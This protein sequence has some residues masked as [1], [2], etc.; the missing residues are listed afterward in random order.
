M[1][2]SPDDLIQVNLGDRSYPIVV[3]SGVSGQIAKYI[4]SGVS[5]IAII[6]QGN[7][8]DLL[9]LAFPTV[10][11]EVPDGEEAKRL[12][13]VERV[14]ELLVDSGF[15]RSD[16]IVNV[17]GGV[18]TDLGGFIAATYH[19]GVRFLNVPTSLLGMVDAAIG[20]KTGV[21]LPRGKNLVG[22]FWQPEAVIC[23]TDYLSSLPHEEY[24][25]GLGELCKY[26][27]I[28]AGELSSLPLDEQIRRSVALKASVVSADER[29][30][31]RRAILNYG[32]TLAHAIE[33]Q[34]FT[35][36][37]G[38]LKHGQAV[39]IG[40]TFAALLAEKLG[41]IDGHRVEEHRRAIARYGLDGRL[42]RWVDRDALPGQM[43][44]DK[45]ADGTLTFVLDG[46][47]GVEV[48]RGVN[49]EIV[50]KVLRDAR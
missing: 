38:E 20:G 18:V 47:S 46:P 34:G 10:R 9:E 31:G 8:P 14:S 27:F 44:T 19:R 22:A 35:K 33:L 11:I 4:P 1:A 41:R 42:P 29:E 28:G 36:A 13:E 15:G 26:E 30:G 25:C 40:V 37:P 45:K 50:R 39:A 49:E 3:G 12:S 5:K 21:N 6:T 7:I 48:V 16:L 24:L 2:G 23:D 32:H 17:G 43:L